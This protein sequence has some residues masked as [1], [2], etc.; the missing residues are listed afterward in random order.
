MMSNGQP[1]KANSKGILSQN[2]CLEF[3]EDFG[4]KSGFLLTIDLVFKYDNF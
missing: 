3:H 1:R 2:D 4:K